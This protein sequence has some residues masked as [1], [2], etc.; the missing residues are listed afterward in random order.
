MKTQFIIIVIALAGCIVNPAPNEGKYVLSYYRSA[1]S[2]FVPDTIDRGIGILA[3]KNSARN[4]ET[5]AYA[6][7][8]DAE[9]SYLLLFSCDS[10]GS[11]YAVGA[12]KLLQPNIIEFDYEICGFPFDSLTATNWAHVILGFDS[13]K[14]PSR[15]W[16]KLDPAI[17]EIHLWTDW[18]PHHSLYFLNQSNFY[19]TVGGSPVAWEVNFAP[20]NYIMHPLN[21]QGAWVQVLVAR[22]SDMCVPPD[23]PKSD[24][25]VAWIKYLD[26]TRRPRVWYYTRGC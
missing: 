8:G 19:D 18:L 7:M 2:G 4:N 9:P 14:K 10:L 24:T 25:L 23:A 13:D 5:S 1:A 11:R 12:D 22:P 15:G 21:S 17:I 6:A 3:F 26:D 16:V 20:R